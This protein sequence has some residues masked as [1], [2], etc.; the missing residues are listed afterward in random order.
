VVATLAVFD[1]VRTH[2]D[3]SY[4]LP[5]E[6]L[7]RPLACIEAIPERHLTRFF[8]YDEYLA[9]MVGKVFPLSLPDPVR[10]E[11][12]LQVYRF[13]QWANRWGLCGSYDIDPLQ[14]Y[15]PYLLN[16]NL[17]FAASE[18]K[19]AFERLLRIGA[20]SYVFS[21][22]TEGMEGL[23]PVEPLPEPTRVYRVPDPLSRSYV[24]GGA[25]VAGD[26]DALR[27]LIDPGF[28]FRRE[29]VLPSG[30]PRAAEAGF[31]GESGIVSFEPDRVRIEAR[32]NRPGYVV[33]V[34]AYDP[35]WRATVDGQ[36]ATLLRANVAFRAVAISAGTHVVEMTY[37]PR[38]LPLGL[39]VSAAALVLGLGL[40]VRSR[41]GSAGPR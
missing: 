20:V 39:G 38:A 4:A 28:D 24:V 15:P 41:L 21:L 2:H 11:R 13:C 19:P 10:R 9:R 8:G 25:R 32:L 14:L 40:L 23:T 17:V 36:E 12:A 27:L 31:S 1:L 30:T 5:R 6:L 18:G 35:D 37:R 3:M 26:L 22:H 16:L 34:D 33:L 7:S 29:V